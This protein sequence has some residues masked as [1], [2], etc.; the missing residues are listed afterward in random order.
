MFKKTIWLSFILGILLFSSCGG[1]SSSSQAKEL[2]KVILEIVGI[3]Q[4]A[5]I[6]IC[7]TD[8]KSDICNGISLNSKISYSNT[9]HKIE[10]ISEGRFLVETEIPCEPI[11][12][13]LQDNDVKYDNG[14]FFLKFSGV[15]KGV[16]SKELSILEA[17]VDASYLQDNL[18]EIKNLNS[19]YAQNEFYSIL[20]KDLKTNIN[21]L[22]EEGLTKTQAIRGTLIEMS[23]ELLSAGVYHALPVKLNECNSSIECIDTEL[24]LLS[25]NLIINEEEAESIYLLQ[26]NNNGPLTVKEVSCE[27]E[28]IEKKF[29][30]VEDIIKDSDLILSKTE[31]GSLLFYPYFS[32]QN[33]ETNHIFFKN[34]TPNAIVAEAGIYHDINTTES[35]SFHIFLAPYDTCNFYIQNRDIFITKENNNIPIGVDITFQTD[36][37]I[38]MQ[39]YDQ[40]RFTIGNLKEQEGY[41]IIYGGTQYSEPMAYENNHK[42]LYSDYLK[43]LDDCRE[44]WREA[45]KT[46]KNGEVTINIQGQK[47]P[48]GCATKSKSKLENIDLKNFVAVEDNSLVGYLE[49]INDNNTTINKNISFNRTD[50]LHMRLPLLGER[51]EYK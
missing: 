43:V 4:E 38:F 33:G 31:N 12:L 46:M 23:K 47:V 27:E 37:I 8:N 14:E 6:N 50:H 39:D 10:E 5:I 49:I 9:S 26:R 42:A 13:E 15:P 3:P 41:I 16:E 21:I 45:Y 25:K 51:M 30:T 11:L 40:D 29:P 32:T 34:N 1:G 19:D 2:L 36:T 18:S 17:M 28:K 24:N 7:Q 44:G 48:A 22:R 20:Y 35:L